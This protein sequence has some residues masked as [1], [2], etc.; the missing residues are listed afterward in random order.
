MMIHGLSGND[1][2]LDAMV[3]LINS[4]TTASAGKWVVWLTGF[5]EAAGVAYLRMRFH[6]FP[7]HPVGLAFQYTIGAWLYWFSLLVVWL[8]KFGLLRFGGV[9]IYVAGKPLFYGMVVG[10]VLGIILARGV[11]RVW[12]PAASHWLHRW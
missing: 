1:R 11:D 2:T 7:F 6:W 12:F 8:A 4:P 9:R 10:Y 5:F 3:R